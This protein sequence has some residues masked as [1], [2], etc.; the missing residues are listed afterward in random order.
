MGRAAM[1]AHSFI[2]ILYMYAFTVRVDFIGLDLEKHPPM[3]NAVKIV[4][5]SGTFTAKLKLP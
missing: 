4:K 3:E 1:I 2:I 5:W